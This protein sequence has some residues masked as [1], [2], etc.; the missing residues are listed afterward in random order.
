MVSVQK[1][2]ATGGQAGEATLSDGVFGT[3]IRNQAVYETVLMQLSNKRTANPT[4]KDRS[5]VR[6]GGRKPWKQKGTG[7]ARA[8]S[9]RSPL[10]RKGGVAMGPDFTNHTQRLPRKLRRVALRSI[11]T[12]KVRE[13]KLSVIAPIV[14]D[15]P[16]TKNVIALLAKLGFAGAKTVF[17]L[18]AKSENFERSVRN[19]PGV[20]TLSLSTINPHDL[21]NH[22]RV[23]LFEDAARKIEE[24]FAV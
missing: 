23:V 8:G 5:E 9:I 15:A 22:E 21:L 24:V 16:K 7:R 10:W 4:T 11:L 20:K 14:Y 19:L 1:F 3:R 12:D 13:G 18:G 17:V 6:G 2:D